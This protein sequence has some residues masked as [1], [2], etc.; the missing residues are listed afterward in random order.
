MS[1]LSTRSA[2]WPVRVSVSPRLAG[3]GCPDRRA[4]AMRWRIVL[5]YRMLR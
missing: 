5:I 4:R 3:G 1:S 2:A